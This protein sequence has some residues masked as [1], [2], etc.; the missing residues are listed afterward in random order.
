MILTCLAT[1]AVS[2]NIGGA[3]FNGGNANFNV[4]PQ[5]DTTYTCI[6]TGANGQTDTAT[7]MVKVTPPPGPPTGP[8]PTVN[9][10]G[11]L[12]QTTIYRILQLDA[13]A[14]TS[15]NL[16]LSFNWVAVPGTPLAITGGNTANPTVQL[17]N[18]TG[19]Y[20]LILTVTDSKGL[21]TTV[22]VRIYLLATHVQ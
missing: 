18:E 16:P 8:G 10:A 2:L 22:T 9:V 11:G 3:L 7:V 5:V 14:S 4:F 6:A 21:S 13:S 17:G 20:D 12:S 19:E 15:P 1:G